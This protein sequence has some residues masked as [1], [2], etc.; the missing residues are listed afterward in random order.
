LSQGGPWYPTPQACPRL[1]LLLV[2]VAMPLE[3]CN[4]LWSS[5]LY[6]PT[7]IIPIIIRA[8]RMRAIFPAYFLYQDLGLMF[9]N[10]RS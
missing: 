7:T 9:I 1:W 8:L 3:A 6:V 2:T 10:P 4:F 5:G